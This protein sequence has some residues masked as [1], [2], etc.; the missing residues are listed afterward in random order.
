LGVSETFVSD[1]E[2][3]SYFVKLEGMR[4][5][6]AA[7]LELA[8]DVL[9]IA[10]GS[11]FYAMALARKHTGVHV[12]AIDVAD[13]DTARENVDQ[14]G[15]SSMVTLREM[16]ATSL[17]FRDESFDHVVNFLGLED[18]HMTRGRVGVEKAFMEAHR[19]LK[20]GGSLCFVAMPSDEPDT[21]AQRNEIEV[22]SWIC[23]A[24]W[25][26]REEYLVLVTD[27]GLTLEYSKVFRTGKKLTAEQSKE[28]IEFACENVPALYGRTAR[29][30]DEAWERFGESITEHGMGHYSR[31][32]L[33][34]TRKKAKQP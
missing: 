9:D 33:F 30:F 15:L 6:V 7:E 11:A 17:L 21:M 3:P 28:E 13:L 20:P 10:T 27:A 34:V 25:L 2:Y 31:L 18:I 32:E 19:V 24:T 26:T 23:D 4:E 1:E 16:D 12:T 22:F 29:G 14:A 5:E 8:G